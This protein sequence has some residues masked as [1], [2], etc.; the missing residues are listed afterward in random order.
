MSEAPLITLLSWAWIAHTIEVDN[1][2]EAAGASRPAGRFQ[3]SLPMWANGLRCIPETGVTIREL[4][5]SSR[6]GC[7]LGGLERWGWIRVATSGRTR[8][9]GYGTRRGLKPDTVVC[10]TEA[11]SIARRL[12][13]EIVATVEERWRKRFGQQVIEAL[14]TQLGAPLSGIPWSPPEVYPTDGFCTHIVTGA[15]DL[16]EL[17]L[18]ALLGQALTAQTVGQERTARVSLPLAANLLR[19]IDGE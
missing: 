18:V 9:D 6:A 19:V 15:G 3:I 8:R 14:R 13:P 10:P 11:G 2:V 7:N 12:F 16:G 5:E 1:A 4:R 17:P